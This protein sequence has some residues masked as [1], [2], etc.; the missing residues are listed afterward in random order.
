MTM[1]NDI[2]MNKKVRDSKSTNHQLDCLD[3]VINNALK[4]AL[5]QDQILPFVQRVNETAEG[6]HRSVKRT[7]KLC[8]KCMELCIK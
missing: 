5:N 2:G 1:V 7:T 4:E 8:S 3:H 6:F